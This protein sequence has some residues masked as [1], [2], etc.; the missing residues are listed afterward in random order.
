MDYS[1]SAK[2][3]RNGNPESDFYKA[4]YELNK[5]RE[6]VSEALSKVRVNVLP[7]RNYQH[8]EGVDAQVEDTRKLVLKLCY[9]L[10]KLE[11][12]AKVAIGYTMSAIADTLEK[13]E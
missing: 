5:A 9:K 6:A 11:I 7:G 2:P 8:L 12:E 1:I 13:L 4:Y 3:Q 10:N